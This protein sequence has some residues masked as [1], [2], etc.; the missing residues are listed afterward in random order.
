VGYLLRMSGE[1]RDWLADL[2]DSDPVAARRVGE[3]LTA[4]IAEGASLG[5]PLVV[6]LADLALPDDPAEALDDS[7]QDRRQQLEDIRGHLAEAKKLVGDIERQVAELQAQEIKLGDQRFR[8]LGDGDPDAAAKAVE[9]LGTVQ[10]KLAELRRLLP[11]VVK[12]EQELRA[13]EQE[14]SASVDAFLTRKETLQA[15]YAAARAEQGIRDAI[16]AMSADLGDQPPER[17]ASSEA[18]PAATLQ[19][20]AGQIKRELGSWGSADDLMELRPGAPGESDIRLLFA[21]EPAGTALLI[22]VLEGHQAV[23]DDHDEAVELSAEVLQQ[24]RYGQAPE[25]SALG[26]DDVPSFLDE[27]FPGSADEVE[28]G[29]AALAARNRARTLA[30]ERARLGLSQREV[31]ERMS[32]RPD[33]VGAIE[34][35]E[36]GATEVRTLARYVEALGGRLEIIADFGDERVVLR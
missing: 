29:A 27:F 34:R 24:V 15:T 35:A 16:T 36:P 19:E 10:A 7:Y 21:V 22:A 17:P 9:E 23:K 6:S 12:A 8:A 2:R 18:K 31:A 13:K 26:F 11:G 33:R 30:G 4:L 25:A 1:I 3:A 32:V 28:A 14:L 5:P 20:V